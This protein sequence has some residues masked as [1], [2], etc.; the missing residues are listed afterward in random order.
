LMVQSFPWNR[1]RHYGPDSSQFELGQ[2]FIQWMKI[3]ANGH[4]D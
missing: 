3:P 1:M 2:I 4:N